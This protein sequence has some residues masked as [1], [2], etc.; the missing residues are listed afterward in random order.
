MSYTSSFGALEDPE[1]SWL[2][3]SI[4]ILIGIYSLIF[5]TSMI[6]ILALYLDFENAKNSYVLLDLDLGL[7]RMVEVPDWILASWF[8]FGYGHWS[9][10]HPWSKIWL[11]FSILKVSDMRLF[12][13]S[14]NLVCYIYAFYLPYIFF[15]LFALNGEVKMMKILTA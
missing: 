9:L 6:Q 7:W 5:D 13:R 3:F 11:S 8:W 10:I 14:L 4:L 15:Q 2:G 12:G 1:G